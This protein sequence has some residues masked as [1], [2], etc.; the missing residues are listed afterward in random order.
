MTECK[1]C[2]NIVVDQLPICGVCKV[3]EARMMGVHR[4]TKDISKPIES[5]F[6]AT[7][8]G[9]KA[10]HKFD[11]IVGISGGVD[12]CF[13]ATLCGEAGL[14]I[15][16]IH[17]DNGWN[18]SLANQNI[19]NI[20]RKYHF[21]LES[22]VMPWPIFR[23]LQRSFLLASVPDVE[24]ITDHAIFS[25]MAKIATQELAPVLFSG[26]NFATEH[27]LDERYLWNKL[28]SLNIKDI[29]RRH[30][31]I[32]LDKYPM[33]SPLKWFKHRFLSSNCRIATPLNDFWY[34]R[35][36]AARI[37]SALHGFKDYEFKHEESYFTKFYQ[38]VI[39]PQ[40]FGYVKAKDHLNALIRNREMSKSH[41][42]SKL[43]AFG[44]LGGVANY[45]TKFVCD[46]LGMDEED[47]ASI[48]K[49]KPVRHSQY[50]NL[51]IVMR[52]SL[53][54]LSALNMRSMA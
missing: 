12:S 10:H 8:V 26:A 39:L 19:D 6:K 21:P 40:K 28:D 31:N 46:K 50:R 23:S 1:I 53:K 34:Q 30:E 44:D 13:I 24:L 41:A 18:S 45:E 36:E 4:L 47:L 2:L 7:E 29:N 11:A 17:F 27:G 38:R 33:I 51:G 9:K 48:L 20:V 42:Q 43:G 54:L 32:C 15:K 16:L 5:M 37:M 35:R 25:Y 3:V 14:N 49:S 22:Y 52:P